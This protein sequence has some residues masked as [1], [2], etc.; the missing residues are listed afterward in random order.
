MPPGPSS[1]GEIGPSIADARAMPQE[2]TRRTAAPWALLRPLPGRGAYLPAQAGD[3]SAAAGGPTHILYCLAPRRTFSRAFRLWR[4]GQRSAER[5]TLSFSDRA[6]SVTRADGFNEYIRRQC[7]SPRSSGDLTV[8]LLTDMPSGAR[9]PV[10]AGLWP[11]DG[12][13]LH[14]YPPWSRAPDEQ[15]WASARSIRSR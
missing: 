5:G 10:P 15:Q 9:G 14:W 3:L 2:P 6:P 7:C 1:S 4:S 11:A 12:S 13:G 8:I